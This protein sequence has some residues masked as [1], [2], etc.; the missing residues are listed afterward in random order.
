MTAHL[1]AEIR[2]IDLTQPLGDAAFARI[3]EFFHR[4]CVIVFRGQKLDAAQLAAFSARFGELDVH[5]MTEHTLPGLPQVRVLSNVKKDGKPIGVSY[6][7]MHWHS[8][9]SYKEK[10]GLATLLYAI[11]CPPSGADTQFASMYAAYEALS[12]AKRSE[13]ASL[14]GVHDRNYRY[15]ALYPNRPP[16]T[17]EQTAKVPPVVHPL[18]VRH[19]ATARAALYVA[20]DVVSGIVGMDD[21]AARKLIDELEAFA[22]GTEFVYSHKW[23]VGDVLVWDN[24]CTLHRATP[25]DTRYGRTLYRTQ[26]KGAV[27]VSAAASIAE[28]SPATAVFFTQA[29][30]S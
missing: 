21:L 9:L 6:G 10:P 23:Q 3:L 1:G 24:R 30:A 18:V 26:V 7:G 13:L 20:K 14:N 27:P 12:A 2:G 15:A 8:D 28:S 25:F 17:P 11:Q 19:P 5:H 4:H 22:T 16:L 29:P